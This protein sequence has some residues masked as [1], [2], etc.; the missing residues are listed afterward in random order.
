VNRKIKLFSEMNSTSNR[1][2]SKNCKNGSKQ[3]NNYN[4]RYFKGKYEVVTVPGAFF[5]MPCE[6]RSLKVGILDTTPVASWEVEAI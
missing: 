3:E 1:L 6:C 2:L 5:Q 4:T